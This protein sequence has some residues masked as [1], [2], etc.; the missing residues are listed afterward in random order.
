MSQ[1]KS[2]WHCPLKLTKPIPV[3]HNENQNEYQPKTLHKH[4]QY[5]RQ[6]LATFPIRI[7][8]SIEEA[9][10]LLANIPADILS[11]IELTQRSS[12][13]YPTP[14]NTTHIQQTSSYI[15]SIFQTFI[16]HLSQRLQVD[17]SIL[18]YN[19]YRLNEIT[20]NFIIKYRSYERSNVL[21]DHHFP[22]SQQEQYLRMLNQ[23]ELC[24]LL[25]YFLQM[26]VD[27]FYMKTCQLRGNYQS[28]PIKPLF[29]TDE[30]INDS[31]D[32]KRCQR[33]Y[34]TLCHESQKSS[35]VKFSTSGH[36]HRFLNNYETI[37]NCSAD[38]QTNNIVYALTCI[39]GEYDYIDSTQYTL[40]DVLEYH[41]QN[42]NR[43]IIEYLLNGEPFSNFCTCIKHQFD[44]QRINKMR[45]YQHFTHCSAALNYFLEQNPKYW[46][47]VPMKTN[48]A[49]FDD[50][51]YSGIKT[52]SKNT[53]QNTIIDSY[54]ARIPQ[55]PH[56]YTFSKRQL[57]EQCEFFET[58]D[59]QQY[60]LD[61]KL[62]YYHASIIA[63]LP[64]PCSAMLRHLIEALF[65]THAETKLNSMNL[66]TSDTSLLYGAPY[67]T[68]GIWC[69]KLIN[70]SINY[71]LASTNLTTFS[72]SD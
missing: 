8:Q 69:E 45:V 18:D 15:Y 60:H 10:L 54:I 13:A 30:I 1:K 21:Y 40:H 29:R 38:C 23:N 49:Q 22:L 70:P 34:C 51:S 58:F 62:D 42:I 4:N 16:G 36:R 43:L 67:N 55:P 35:T 27:L 32:M 39:C 9:P 11:N 68:K 14:F 37:L 65:V 41:R 52:S 63:L 20:E 19:L 47:F 72:K 64:N 46:C 31:H 25:E 44:R 48:D 33:F 50:L 61:S 56:D 3:F 71:N 26:D 24:I 59:L 53:K 66:F 7:D 57:N 28:L 5:R 17:S 2:K 12:S 6:F